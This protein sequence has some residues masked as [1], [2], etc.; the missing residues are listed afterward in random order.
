MA[1]KACKPDI[2]N[3]VLKLALEKGRTLP[4]GGSGNLRR[5]CGDADDPEKQLLNLNPVPD[6]Y[7]DTQKPFSL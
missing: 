3:G 5:R 2:R 7:D 6:A 1:E 4:G